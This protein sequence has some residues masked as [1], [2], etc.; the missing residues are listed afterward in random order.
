MVKILFYGS[1]IDVS[2]EKLFF[3][4]NKSIIFLYWPGLPQ[5]GFPDKRREKESKGPWFMKIN[6]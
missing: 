1:Y 2:V 4:E 3:I 5:E 6:N